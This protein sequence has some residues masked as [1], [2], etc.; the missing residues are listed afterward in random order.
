MGLATNAI[1]ARAF[2]SFEPV[3]RE[4]S[5]FCRRR[6]VNRRLGGFQQRFQFG[7]AFVKWH[8]RRSRSPLQSR[9]KN[10]QDAGVC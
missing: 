8:V 6:D 1:E 5:I 2:E 9:S 10:T 7:A 4:V 3:Q